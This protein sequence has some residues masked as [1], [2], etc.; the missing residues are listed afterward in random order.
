M[1]NKILQIQSFLQESVM[2]LNWLYSCVDNTNNK[3]AN[4]P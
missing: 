2:F 4:M 1:P 3:A